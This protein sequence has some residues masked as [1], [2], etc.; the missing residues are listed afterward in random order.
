[1]PAPR[2]STEEP[3]G[4]PL[5]LTGPLKLDSATKPRLLIAWY[6]AAPPAVS[7]IM[8]SSWRR[9]MDIPIVPSPMRFPWP[10]LRE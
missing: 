10:G 3:F 2:I 4:A 6:I 7:P 5:R 9:V 8:R 1:M